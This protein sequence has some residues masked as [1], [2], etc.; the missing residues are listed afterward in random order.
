[1]KLPTTRQLLVLNT[2]HVMRE[3]NGQAPSYRELMGVLGFSSLNAVADHMRL[4]KK[5]GLVTWEPHK[6]RTLRLTPA[7]LDLVGNSRGSKAV[8]GPKE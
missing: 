5:K 8:E 6:A 1:M 3:V 4:L 2:I 7:G